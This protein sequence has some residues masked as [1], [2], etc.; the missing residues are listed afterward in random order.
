MARS[1]HQHPLAFP[2][3]VAR[4]LCIEP[5][6]VMDLIT[7]GR[8]PS[9]KIPKRTRHVYRI[10]L[11][12][13]HEWLKSHRGNSE[14]V[15]TSYQTFLADFD[16]VRESRPQKGEAGGTLTGREGESD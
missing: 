7:S 9:V 15:F 2:A 6:D 4:Y 12:D 10:P 13:F 11:R 8:L 14:R 16:S 3:E 5:T 1:P